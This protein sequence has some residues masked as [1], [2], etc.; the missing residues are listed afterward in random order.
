MAMD[1]LKAADTRQG[2]WN[3]AR[4]PS[5]LGDRP[6]RNL[7]S[8][9]DGLVGGVGGR[10]HRAPLRWGRTQASAARHPALPPAWAQ[11]GLSTS[12]QPSW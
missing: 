6:T 12:A 8:M 7:Q 4:L 5:G 10:L 2:R 3:P 11:A 9:K 1:T